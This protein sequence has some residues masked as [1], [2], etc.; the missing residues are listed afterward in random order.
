M[1]PKTCGYL[2]E[3]VTSHL[4]WL[5]AQDDSVSQ[6][7]RDDVIS[8]VADDDRATYEDLLATVVNAKEGGRSLSTHFKVLPPKEVKFSFKIFQNTSKR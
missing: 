3:C 7:S 1:D 4:I 2:T 8:S 5:F 6:D